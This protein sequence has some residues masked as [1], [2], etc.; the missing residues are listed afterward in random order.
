MLLSGSFDE[1]LYTNGTKCGLFVKCFF[2]TSQM[3]V[4]SFGVKSWKEKQKH[5]LNSK[6]VSEG[7]RMPFIIGL[8]KYT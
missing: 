7:N 4:K 5:L 6:L 3:G 2:L 1:A 8:N